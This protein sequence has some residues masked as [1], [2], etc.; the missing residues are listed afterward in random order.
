MPQEINE[1]PIIDSVNPN[2]HFD[3]NGEEIIWQGKRK[4]HSVGV[5]Q[6]MLYF[7]V[8]AFFMWFAWILVL[9]ISLWFLIFA[10]IYNAFMLW[11]IY[12]ASNFKSIHL[13][14]QGLVLFTRFSGDIFYR[15]GDFV[16]RFDI[17]IGIRFCEDI[18]ITNTKQQK[19]SFIFPC[20]YD[21]F[22]SFENNR[23]FKELCTKYTQQALESM[24]IIEKTNLY[25]IYTI[26]IVI[27]FNEERN[28]NVFMIDFLP[29]KQEIEHYLRD[30][31]E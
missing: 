4:Y 1:K 19:R 9:D 29:Y 31:N 21:S 3:K 5:F 20:G 17:P 14:Q 6:Y 16:I 18:T 13:T 23:D 10:I 15:Y 24:D 12:N 11:Q 2:S 28:S 7:I 22:G 30:K 26:N 8:G 27:M 25:K